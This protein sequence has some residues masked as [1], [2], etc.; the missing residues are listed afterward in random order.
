[1]TRIV[2]ALVSA[3]L[4]TAVCAA[5]CAGPSTF[6]S[7]APPPDIEAHAW[8]RSGVPAVRGAV[9]RAMVENGLPVDEAA[10]GPRLLVASRQQVPHVRGAAAPA[11]GPLPTYTLTARLSPAGG[12]HVEATVKVDC[13]SCDGASAYEWEYPGDIVRGVFRTAAKMLGERSPRFQYPPRF[14]PARWHP[15]PPR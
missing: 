15:P 10:S 5:G 6:V 2:R 11:P 4:V 1:V 7:S 13:P 8:F 3:T 9:A 14:R 12:T